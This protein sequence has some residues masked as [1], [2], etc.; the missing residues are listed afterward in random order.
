MAIAD[1][2]SSGDTLEDFTPDWI[3]LRADISEV[4][5]SSWDGSWYSD[6]LYCVALG[7]VLLRRFIMGYFF[8]NG[9]CTD[10]VFRFSGRLSDFRVDFHVP[11]SASASTHVPQ[12]IVLCISLRTNTSSAHEALYVFVGRDDRRW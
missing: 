6:M 5:T 10:A 4:R 3:C 2:A 9:K 8:W 7:R 1:R 12:L 11:S